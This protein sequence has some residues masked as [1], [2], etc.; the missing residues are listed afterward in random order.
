LALVAH[1]A[2]ERRNDPERHTTRLHIPNIGEAVATADYHAAM[3]GETAS[4]IATAKTKWHAGDDATRSSRF[5]F[6]FC[7]TKKKDDRCSL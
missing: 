6:C 1:V 4:V 5:F 2:S 3:R 7:T